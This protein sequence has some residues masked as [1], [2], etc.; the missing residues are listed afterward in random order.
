MSAIFGT[1]HMGDDRPVEPAWLVAI[2][3]ALAGCG[4]HG[5]GAWHHGGVALGARILHDTPEATFERQPLQSR[6]GSAI[7]VADAR[8]DNREDLLGELSV[9]ADGG[10]PVPDSALIMAAWTRWGKD[11][12]LHLE[13][14]FAFALWDARERQLMCCR[15][16]MGVKPFYYYHLPGRFFLFASQLAGL[17]ALESV[18]RQLDRQA[19]ADHLL[20]L[21]D[22][23]RRTLFAGVSRLPRG[24][25]LIAGVNGRLVIDR[26][27]SLAPASG[28]HLR[29]EAEWAAAM[30]AELERATRVRMRATGGIGAHLS[31]GLDSSAVLCLAARQQGPGTP[32]LLALSFSSPPVEGRPSA[33]GHYIRDVVEQTGVP[34]RYAPFDPQ[35]S[36]AAHDTAAEGMLAPAYETEPEHR[37]A[38]SEGLRVVLSGW[39]GDEGASFNGRGYLPS[40]L[41]SGR[42]LE[43][44]RVLAGLRRRGKAQRPVP[45]IISQA[46]EPLLPDPVYYWFHARIRHDPFTDRLR[47]ACISPHLVHELSLDDRVNRRS[48]RRG[49]SVRAYQLELLNHGHVVRRLESWSA[50]ATRFG[51]EYRYPLLDRRLLELCLAMPEN[52]WIRDGQSRYAFRLALEGIL[53]ES[54]RWRGNKADSIAQREQAEPR[55]KALAAL[56]ESVVARLERGGNDLDGCISLERLRN[57]LDQST[58]PTTGLMARLVAS[59]SAVLAVDLALFVERHGIDCGG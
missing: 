25:R 18:P 22:D 37:W 2:S 19:A 5:D 29:S 52:L 15:D 12:C 27:G 3:S 42:W 56:H 55:L 49:T 33:D 13:G 24:H 7:L 9:D 45:Y 40:L 20:M 50:D 38:C 30:R 11:C 35:L 51:L 4:P 28:L 1:L 58:N 46:V 32:S 44:W 16:I 39:G 36:V 53:P 17:L 8:L 48:L 21:L 31:G 43:L 41:R 47:A 14:D 10:G 57:R 6:D 54:V 23:E 34:L 59:S 26:Y